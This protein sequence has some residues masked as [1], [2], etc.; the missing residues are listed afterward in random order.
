MKLKRKQI[1]ALLKLISEGEYTDLDERRNEQDDD[2]Y[3]ISV[4]KKKRKKR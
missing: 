4:S 3:P 2:P 1:K